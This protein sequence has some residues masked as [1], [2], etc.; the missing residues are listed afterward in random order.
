MQRHL[1]GNHNNQKLLIRIDMNGC[2]KEGYKVYRYAKE[3]QGY[4]ELVN[5][6]CSV[7]LLTHYG[8]QGDADFRENLD[9]LADMLRNECGVPLEYIHGLTEDHVKESIKTPGIYLLKN[10]RSHEHESVEGLNELNQFFVNNFDIFIN[11]APAVSHRKDTTITLSHHMDSRVGNVLVEELSRLDQVNNGSKTLVWGGAKLDKSKYV[12][13]LVKNGWT[14]LLGGI[15]AIEF[16]KGAEGELQDLM[17]FSHRFVEPVDW[18]T[19]GKG[20]IVD[21]GPKT[22]DLYESKLMENKGIFS[23]PM[24][25]YEDGYEESSYRLMVHCK[26]ILGGHS[27]NI[28]HK[29]KLEGVMTSGGAALAYISGKKLPGLEKFET[30]SLYEKSPIFIKNE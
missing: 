4:K 28:A 7:I 16:A 30:E 19:N 26:A 14:V 8:R 27:G 29:R 21:I 1:F 20:T 18:V 5:N 10:T 23:G 15:P 22:V 3:M 13:E 11:D 17:G 25:L 6:G 2:E 9:F 12:R 24:G